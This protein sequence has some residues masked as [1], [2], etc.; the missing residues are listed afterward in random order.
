MLFFVCLS[1]CL[2]FIVD[3]ALFQFMT[4]TCY[5]LA[6][7]VSA[8]P[9]STFLIIQEGTLRRILEGWYWVPLAELVWLFQHLP[10]S[11]ILQLP[12]VLVALHR[13]C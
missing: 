11:Q 7:H 8:E 2:F 3:P 13:I 6:L 4:L 1:V 10:S 9:S 12:A 5:S